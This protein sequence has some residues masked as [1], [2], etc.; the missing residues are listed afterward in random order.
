MTYT[1]ALCVHLGTHQNEMAVEE[2]KTKQ[3]PSDFLRK[4]RH[5]ATADY[6]MIL[7]FTFM[8]RLISASV[9]VVKVFAC[10]TGYLL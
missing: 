6:R 5:A 10:C 9:C 3:A 4:F 7:L 8:L 1:P 2:E